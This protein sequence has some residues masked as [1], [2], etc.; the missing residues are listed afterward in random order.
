MLPTFSGRATHLR[1]LTPSLPY[2]KHST[3]DVQNKLK[4]QT[5]KT[6][7]SENGIGEAPGFGFRILLEARKPAVSKNR[8]VHCI[9]PESGVRYQSAEKS[10]EFCCGRGYW[11]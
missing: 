1:T 6:K 5:G 4:G 3:P 2:A 10:G 11:P 9:R 7:E 8:L